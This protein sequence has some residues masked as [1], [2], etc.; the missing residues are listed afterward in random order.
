MAKKIDNT[1]YEEENEYENELQAKEQR[2]KDLLTGSIFITWF[3]V[4]LSMFSIAADLE[5]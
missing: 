3:M 5:N 2:K 4:S 1:E